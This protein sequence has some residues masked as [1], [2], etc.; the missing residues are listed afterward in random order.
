[1]TEVCDGG[2]RKAEGIMRKGHHLAFR[3]RRQARSDLQENQAGNQPYRKP[4]PFG[5]GAM[6]LAKGRAASA[7]A[8]RAAFSWYGLVFVYG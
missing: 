7:E 2:G 8:G 1:L 4:N 6:I 3:K 5:A